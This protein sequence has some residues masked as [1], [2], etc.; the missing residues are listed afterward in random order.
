MLKWKKGLFIGMIAAVLTAVPATG[1]ENVEIENTKTNLET[2]YAFLGTDFKELNTESDFM[3]GMKNVEIMGKSGTISFSVD[4]D[5][6]DSQIRQMTWTGNETA[7]EQDYNIFLNQIIDYYGGVKGTLGNYD[8]YKARSWVNYDSGARVYCYY[9]RNDN[10]IIMHWNY[11]EHFVVSNA[12]KERIDKIKKEQDIDNIDYGDNT[13][14]TMNN[15]NKSN[16]SSYKSKRQCDADGCTKSGINE[17]YIFGECEYYCNEHYQEVMDTVNMMEEDVGNGTAS[18]HH[19]EACN[20]EGTHEV[21]GLG[22]T[23]YYCTEHYNE[24]MGYIEKI[25]DD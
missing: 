18:K 25:L 3:N 10:T 7:T 19:C 24:L 2:Y 17:C 20:K 22:G 23:E 12:D 6:S 16:S 5:I 21:S 11:D 9:N 1:A 14:T 13:S 8:S 4:E 15:S